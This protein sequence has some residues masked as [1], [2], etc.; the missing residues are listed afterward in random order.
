VGSPVRRRRREARNSV[1]S[2]VGLRRLELKADSP[3][4]PLALRRTR[5]GALAYPTPARRPTDSDRHLAPRPP[6]SWLLDRHPMG[7]GLPRLSR[8]PERFQFHPPPKDLRHHHQPEP[9]QVRSR[10][11]PRDSYRRPS[12]LHLRLRPGHRRCV[13]RY[14]GRALLPRPPDLPHP[15]PNRRR[16]P[17]ALRYRVRA[18][19]RPHQPGPVP[20]TGRCHPA[21]RIRWMVP[22]VRRQLVR[23]QLR[24]RWPVSPRRSL[25]PHHRQRR[26]RP[27]PG[28]PRFPFLPRPQRRRRPAQS[29]PRRAQN[30]QQALQ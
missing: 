21:R 22:S 23:Q 27:R 30:G 29:P 17:T 6:G 19:A 13:K 15:P 11:Q 14:R 1:S 16:R 25:R 3:A 4:R 9:H 5:W 18:P 20:Q 7:R 28:W 24:R 8:P 10:H 2:V 26:P 12:L